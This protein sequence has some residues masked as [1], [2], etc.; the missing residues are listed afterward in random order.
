M[1]Y[2]RRYG[3]GRG[4]GRRRFHMR[5]RSRGFR[6]HRRSFGRHHAVGGFPNATRQS[7]GNVRRTS[8]LRLHQPS[9]MPDFMFVKLKYL[10]VLDRIPVAPTD[11]LLYNG[12]GLLDPNNASSGSTSPL[13][14]IEWMSFYG[15]Y[16]CF[17]S[18]FSGKLYNATD[19]EGLLWSLYPTFNVPTLPLIMINTNNQ[20]YSQYGI[21][22][23]ES[24]NNIGFFT[25]YM[26]TRK[27][28]G[29]V[30][31]SLAFVGTILANPSSDWTWVF[32]V[33]VQNA[34]ANIAYTLITE[35]IYYVKFFDKL[36]LLQAT[37][38]A[39][40]ALAIDKAKRHGILMTAAEVNTM[41]NPPP[42]AQR[43]FPVPRGHSPPP[44][45]PL[46]ELILKK[47]PKHKPEKPKLGPTGT[48]IISSDDE[49]AL[50]VDLIDAAND[51]TI[52]ELIL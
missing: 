43:S 44:T 29:D 32:N 50:M 8:S 21:V 17:G 35:V 12:N 45:P 48:L 9:M 39:A 7:G 40:R 2:N 30:I 52:P 37:P 26:N 24:S 34:L 31:D 11:R 51:Q 3:R 42:F 20:P 47:S 28:R 46:P 13:G 14:F 1:P 36:V 19:S 15:R 5:R 10:D 6:G 49:D 25:S 16:R 18:S 33:E 22:A 27:L 4:R 41:T 23:Q 38:A